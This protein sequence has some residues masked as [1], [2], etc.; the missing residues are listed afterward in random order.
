MIED[1]QILSAPDREA[2]VLFKE[3]AGALVKIKQTKDDFSH[4]Q[5]K[6]KSGGWIA[7]KALIPVKI[8]DIDR[9]S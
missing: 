5:Q 3:R 2:T 6:E 7:T 9:D 1:S 8:K 4:I